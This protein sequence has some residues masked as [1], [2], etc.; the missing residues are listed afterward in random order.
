MPERIST[1]DL[2]YPARTNINP[3]FD[4]NLLNF[5]LHIENYFMK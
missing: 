1:D 2:L 5:Y 4:A 3:E